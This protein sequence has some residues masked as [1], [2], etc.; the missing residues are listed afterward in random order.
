MLEEKDLLKLQNGSDIRGV[1]M[2]TEGGPPVTLPPAAVQRIT[3][4][5]VRFLAVR[6]EKPIRELTV[7]VG[8]DSRLT[9]QPLREE[10]LSAILALGAKALDCGMASTPAMFMALQFDE[11]KAD[12]SIMLTASHLP[13]DRNGM[14]FFTQKGGLE[15]ADITELL[16][17]AAVETPEYKEIKATAR[18]CALITRYTRFL[19]DR[20][21]GALPELGERPLD[22]MRILVDAGNGAGGFFASEVL[23]PLGADVTGSLYLEPDGHFPNHVPNPE[24]AE[25]MKTIQQAVTENHADLGLI[26]D[27]DVDRMGAVL[28]DG[29]TVSRNELIA[30]IAAILAPEHPGGVIVTDSVTSDELTEFLEKELHLKHHRFKRGYKNVINESIRLRMEGIDSPLAIETSGHGAMAENYFLDDGA[31]LAVKLLIAAAKLRQQGKPLSSLIEKLGRPAESREYRLHIEG[32][33]D[34]QAVGAE[35]LK[36]FE[37]KARAEGVSVA[38][39]SYEGVRLIF[40]EGWALFRMSLHDPEMPLNVEGK[41]P[42]SV[43]RIAKSLEKFLQGIE[44]LDLSPLR[45]G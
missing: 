20:I 27:T 8:T 29:A 21:K 17:A 41:Q 2:E 25:A 32:A 18:P 9:A 43:A 6:T 35:A 36:R 16:K 11:T 28:P 34:A 7:A 1:V 38:E 26:F 5:F 3:A 30:M 22:G 42:G 33:E 37:E 13:S 14:K 15:K 40:P 44:G 12:G 4:A 31:Y 45:K 23:K 39:P 10:A 24:N 19:R